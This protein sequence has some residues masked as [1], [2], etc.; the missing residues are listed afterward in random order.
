MWFATSKIDSFAANA[1]GLG[2]A[3]CSECDYAASFEVTGAPRFAPFS[4]E[5]TI[6]IAFQS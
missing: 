4:V 1:E 3:G 6:F 2:G 5:A